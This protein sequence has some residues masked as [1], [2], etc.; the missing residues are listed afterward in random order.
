MAHVTFTDDNF[1]ADV[2]D[3][4]KLVVVDFYATWCGPC[5]MMGP[6]IDELAEEMGDVVIGKMNI[7][8]NEKTPQEHGVMSIP[9]VI[10]VKGGEV[11]E[12]LVGYQSKEA[13]EEKINELK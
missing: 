13:L 11:V 12:K 6:H 8:E 4:D 3:S 1:Q 9:T 10:F 2:L 5:Q 7:D